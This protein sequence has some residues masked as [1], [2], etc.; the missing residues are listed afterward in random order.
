MSVTLT[1]TYDIDIFQCIIIP[2]VIASKVNLIV[3]V[4]HDTD[5]GGSRELVESL[6]VAWCGVIG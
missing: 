3:L 6:T 2:M 5:V 1:T 4:K